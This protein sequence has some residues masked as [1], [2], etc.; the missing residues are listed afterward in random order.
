MIH[1]HSINLLHLFDTP[2]NI[3]VMS[4]IVETIM[5]TNADQK[6]SLGFALHIQLFINSKVGMSTHLL[7]REHLPLLPKFGDNVLVM[8][9]TGNY[10]S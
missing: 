5:R 2:Q 3:K 8:E 9:D 6:R 7:D 10:N 4:L 1:G